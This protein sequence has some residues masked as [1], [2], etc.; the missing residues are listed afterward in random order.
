[1]QKGTMS[2]SCAVTSTHI[3][4]KVLEA[5]TRCALRYIITRHVWM[6]PDALLYLSAFGVTTACCAVAQ[7]PAA[8][9]QVS[10][11]PCGVGQ[12][13]TEDSNQ[14][15]PCPSSSYSF[16]PTVGTCKPCPTG[17]TCTGGATLVPEQQFWHSAPDSDHIVTCPNNNACAGNTSALLACQSSV[18]QAQLDVSQAG[19]RCIALISLLLACTHC[20]SLSLILELLNDACIVPLGALSTASMT[21]MLRVL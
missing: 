6:C 21:F 4:S 17:A 15:V 16:D 13:P 2:G 9:L 8:F 20:T 18:Y 14:C 10:V 11:Q 3:Q 5:S 12:V 7:V 1:M 19:P